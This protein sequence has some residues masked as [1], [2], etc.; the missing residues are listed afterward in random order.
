MWKKAGNRRTGDEDPAVLLTRPEVLEQIERTC[1]RWFWDENLA[2]EAYIFVLDGLKKDDFRKLRLYQGG[3]SL[4]TYLYSCINSLASDFERS[5]FGRKRLP[6]IVIDLGP[7]AE[8][9]FRL[10]C[11]KGRSLEAAFH[12]VRLEGLFA[13]TW[14]DFEKESA[15]IQNAPCRQD[16]RQVSLT[17]PQGE[18]RDP[19]DPREENPLER[20]LAKLDLERRL[21]AAGVIREITAGLSAGDQE[22]VRLVFGSDL[23]VAAAG[24]VVGMEGYQARRRLKKL[25]ARFREALLAEGVREP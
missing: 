9:V 23:T 20:L 3:A 11:W 1:R 18:F 16:P 24:K 5:R 21:K 13:G 14:A 10:I 15:P 17:D 2:D 22:L 25:L 7:W 4:R 12:E 8:R 19:P 6:K